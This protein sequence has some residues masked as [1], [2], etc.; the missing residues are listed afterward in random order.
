LL[1]VTKLN[2]NQFHLP[3]KPHYLC[4]QIFCDA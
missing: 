3:L 2:L 4:G 1:L